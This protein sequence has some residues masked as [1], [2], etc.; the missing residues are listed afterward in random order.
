M[1]ILV[2]FRFIPHIGLI[3]EETEIVQVIFEKSEEI[4]KLEGVFWNWMESFNRE[5]HDYHQ[6]LEELQTRVKITPHQQ[7]WMKISPKAFFSYFQ[8]PMIT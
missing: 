4:V 7:K 2:E 3:P 8:A 5:A 1:T 6:Y